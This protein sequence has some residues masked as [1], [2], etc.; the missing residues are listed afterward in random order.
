MSQSL[1]T[2]S[3]GTRTPSDNHIACFT[4]RAGLCI[5]ATIVPTSARIRA[6]SM[7]IGC[8]LPASI[9]EIRTRLQAGLPQ[10]STVVDIANSLATVEGFV[11]CMVLANRDRDGM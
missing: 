6:T 9:V 11:V 8:Y 4:R 5:K 3:S 10:A 2:T 7:R 1:R